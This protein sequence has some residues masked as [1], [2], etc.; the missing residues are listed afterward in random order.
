MVREG[1]SP[2]LIARIGS[3]LPPSLNRALVLL[4]GSP[5]AEEVLPL[6]KTL[7]GRPLEQVKLLRW[8]P[9]W[10]E[11]HEA[12][13]YLAQVAP[14]LETPGLRVEERTQ[15]GGRLPD[16]RQAGRDSDFVIIATHGR[17]GLDRLWHGSLAEHIT[18][19]GVMPALIVRGRAEPD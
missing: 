2:V 16:I 9:T 19:E 15:V 4:D 3:D 5:L 10:D 12:S 17:S 7:A 14:Q 11:E 1:T 18:T 8:V 13:E 6:V